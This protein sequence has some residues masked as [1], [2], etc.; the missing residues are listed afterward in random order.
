MQIKRSSKWRTKETT[1]T[2]LSIP[3]I[4][5]LIEVKDTILVR[6]NKKKLTS[7]TSSRVISIWLQITLTHKQRQPQ[8]SSTELKISI[9]LGHNQNMGQNSHH[10]QHIQDKYK[11]QKQH[12]NQHSIV[13]IAK[14]ANVRIIKSSVQV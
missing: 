11:N 13:Q 8:S 1:L 3:A 5:C 2:M 14:T 4:S 10:T 6:L 7:C 12:R 9:D